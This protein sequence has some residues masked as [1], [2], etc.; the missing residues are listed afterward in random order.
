M[1]NSFQSNIDM[2]LNV[3]K[4]QRNPSKYLEDQLNMAMNNN[5]MLKNI[6][7]L[8]KNGKNNSA[9]EN[10]MKSICKEYGVDPNSSIDY[11]RKNMK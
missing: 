6:I 11:I 8:F 9:L 4:A 7:P 3:L 5:P 1:N 2:I 10:V